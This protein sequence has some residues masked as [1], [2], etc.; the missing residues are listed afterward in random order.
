MKKT[1]MALVLAGALACGGAVMAE[2]PGLRED[3]SGIRV[4]DF[5]RGTLT[6]K[7]PVLEDESPLMRARVN[8]AVEAEIAFFY[9]RIKKMNDISPVS[10]WVSYYAGY[11]DENF[12]SLVLIETTYPEGAAHPTAYV[13]GMT[14]DRMGYRV[15][16]PQILYMIPER[17]KEE[18]TAEIERQA[19]ERDIG[20]FD[21]EYRSVTGWPEEFYVGDDGHVH[22]IFQQYDLAPYAA[23]WFSVDAGRNK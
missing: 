21:P 10:A 16:R 13:R 1:W 19:A 22:F 2:Q 12:V 11:K 5:S 9:E 14:F 20:L 8:S 18:I 23:G 7:V 17:T 4:M 6:A 3:V 15:T